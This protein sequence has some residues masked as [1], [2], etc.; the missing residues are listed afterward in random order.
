MLVP[1]PKT[2]ARI[3]SLGLLAGDSPSVGAPGAI[4]VG[5]FAGFPFP[6]WRST[7]PT[8]GQALRLPGVV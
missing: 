2:S 1:M 5:P 6:E 3:H 7:P 8:L 4:W